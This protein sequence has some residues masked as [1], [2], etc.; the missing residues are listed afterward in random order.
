MALSL[1]AVSS[2]SGARLKFNFIDR[3]LEIDRPTTPVRR[4]WSLAR[5]GGSSQS[6]ET[7]GL[8]L[9]GRISAAE[10]RSMGDATKADQFSSGIGWRSSEVLYSHLMPVPTA[11]RR[12][13]GRA[14]A[15]FRYIAGMKLGPHGP[16][17]PVVPPFKAAR[18]AFNYFAQA[19]QRAS[20]RHK[21]N[22]LAGSPAWVGWAGLQPGCGGR[23]RFE[24]ASVFHGSPTPAVFRRASKPNKGHAGMPADRPARRQHRQ[25]ADRRVS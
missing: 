5:V 7:R 4:P 2:A 9:G 25:A 6:D 19:Q 13:A 18:Q 17:A 3:Q 12:A 16:D 23:A 10:Q 8:G 15:P 1:D 22:R 24:P 14:P 20:R 21:H 11:V